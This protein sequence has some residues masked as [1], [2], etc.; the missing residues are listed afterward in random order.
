MYWAGT[1]ELFYVMMYL[2][3]RQPCEMGIVGSYILQIL[4]IYILLILQMRKLK[5][6]AVKWVI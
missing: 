4:L 1:R 2:K 3:L 6:R 5:L